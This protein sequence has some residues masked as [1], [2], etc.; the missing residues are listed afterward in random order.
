M[1]KVISIMLTA[2]LLVS[3]LVACGTADT[4]SETGASISSTV[5]T[6]SAELESS[7]E[8]KAESVAFE[9]S[10]Q[11]SETES[12]AASSKA[13]ESKAESSAS[14]A[15]SEAVTN[16]SQ[17]A[18]AAENE[19]T[20]DNKILI[21]YFT[22]AENIEA[23]AISG[24]T[25]I[26]DGYGSVRLL[27]NMIQNKVGGDLFSIQTEEK[28]PAEYNAAADF[29]KEQTDSNARPA[30]ST[31]VENMDEY[32]TVFIGYCAWWYDMPMSI[33][34]FLDEYDLTGKN[35]YVF[36]T[37]E[38]SGT[39]GGVQSIAN[40]EPGAA[41]ESNALSISGGRVSADLQSDVDSWLS[42]LGF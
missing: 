39:P 3:A 20:N 1:K 27:A 37:H 13:A 9:E 22:H 14:S 15:E 34:S 24:A 10:P 21:V 4:A 28:Y 25:P 26:I 42:Q 36:N 29:A 32:D 31:H 6:S 18:S 2:A 19:Q 12:K 11:E 23:D 33:Y 17:A 7:S 38:G 30:L 16:E 40:E 5:Q 35:V 8:T 41:V